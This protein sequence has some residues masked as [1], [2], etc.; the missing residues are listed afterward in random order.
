LEK[1]GVVEQKNHTIVEVAH[2]ILRVVKLS[3]TF[4]VEAISIAC[5]IQNQILISTKPKNHMHYGHNINPTLI[6]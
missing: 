3:K 6:I 1:N 5:Y 2:N 4:W